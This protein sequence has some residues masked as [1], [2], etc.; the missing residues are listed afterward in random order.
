MRWTAFNGVKKYL[1]DAKYREI[2]TLIAQFT[3]TLQITVNIII[4]KFKRCTWRQDLL[5]M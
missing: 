3:N 1:I 4:G 2:I 5:R